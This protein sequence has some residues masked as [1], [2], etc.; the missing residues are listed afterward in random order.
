MI[1]IAYLLAGAVSG[2]ALLV[3]T[4]GLFEA[5][6]FER[7]NFRGRRVPVG[8]GI[9]APLATL[10]TLAIIEL[11]REAADG[12]ASAGLQAGEASTL[13]AVL[14]FGLLGIFDD[15][16]ASG[17][18]RGFRGH[19]RAIF[20]ASWS[21]GAVKLVGGALVGLYAASLIHHDPG[22]AQLL[23]DGGL[24][25][26]AA[27][28]GNLF[29]RAPGRA[30]KV[31]TALF[32][33]LAVGVALDEGAAGAALT[34]GA[35]LAMIGADLRERL[36]LGDAGANALGAAAGVAAVATTPAIVR[37]VIVGA[38]VAV[39]VASERVS[40]SAVIDQTPVLRFIDRLGR[41]T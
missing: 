20:S 35:G 10:A 18:T 37:I 29:D 27:N 13:A 31:V 24:I 3:L 21:T 4:S 16:A 26:L 41:R 6:V 11:G 15:L 38:L 34:I 39:N 12:V 17:D 25:A 1:V 28:T 32:A 7:T 19:V 2:F 23:I 8:V 33:V 22:P 14:G 40:F 36:M 9:V 30:I 5:P